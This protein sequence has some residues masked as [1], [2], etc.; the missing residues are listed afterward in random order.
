MQLLFVC[1][2]NIC[3]SPTAERLTAAWSA[4]TGRTDLAASSAGTRA[5]VGGP[6]EP[7]A[8]QILSNLGGT[9]DGFAARQLNPAIAGTADLILTMTESHRDAV[10]RTAPRQLKRTF[11]LLEA[12]HLARATGSATVADLA[13][14][15]GQVPR[16][17]NVDVPD[18]IGRSAIVFGDVGSQIDEALL[19][20]LPR[21]RD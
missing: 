1:T 7:T 12:T 3:R 5:V 9:P 20:L 2:G 21:L 16:P 19:D 14:V 18:P 4:R 17:D 13:A 10:L 11:T 15:R 8:A 6:M